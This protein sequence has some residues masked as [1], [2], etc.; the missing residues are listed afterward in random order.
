MRHTSAAFIQKDVMAITKK[1]FLGAFDAAGDA[2]G[3]R[4]PQQEEDE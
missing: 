4:R 2:A 3:L 1:R